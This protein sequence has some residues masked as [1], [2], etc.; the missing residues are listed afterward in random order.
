MKKAIVLILCFTMLLSLAGCGG[1]NG[2]S[3][4]DLTALMDE[5][6]KTDSA[7]PEM[8]TVTE[9]SENAEN[10]FAVLSSDFDYSKIDK[11]IYSY[12]DTGSPEEIAVVYV[13]DKATVGD[14]MKSL[15]AHIDSR[16]GTFRAYSPEK[17][18]VVEGA[19]LT[20]QG[21]YVLLAI[22]PTSGAM[23][24]VFKEKVG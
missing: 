7:L 15:Q 14:L 3:S 22:T 12:S 13:E 20:Y 6:K 11:F 21:R 23:Q 24:D 8:S 19:A 16:L 4:V 18:S 9:T 2:G 5:M 17:A 10:T 1:D